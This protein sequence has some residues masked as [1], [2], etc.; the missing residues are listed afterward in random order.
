M[1]WIG[2]AGW[3]WSGRVT[4]K[5]PAMS[6]TT[7]APTPSTSSRCF[8]W[9][10]LKSRLCCMRFPLRQEEL[11]QHQ[12]D[13]VRCGGQGEDELVAVGPFQ[14][15]ADEFGEEHSAQRAC[16]PADADD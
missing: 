7:S 14:H 2:A 9:D 5:R 16:H 10:D 1:T 11:N 13:Q 8:R 12:P 6:N 4:R 15:V 3:Y